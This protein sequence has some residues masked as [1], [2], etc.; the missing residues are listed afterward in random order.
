MDMI[1]IFQEKDRARLFERIE[2]RKL[3]VSSEIVGSVRQI[4]SQV[5]QKGDR[6]LLDFTAQF[7]KIKMT[8]RQLRVRPQ[9]LRAAA[10]NAD[11]ALLRE[12]EK[13]IF[14]IHAYHSREVQESWEYS[15][16]GVVL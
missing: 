4:I 1:R 5:Q 9:L 2:N 14:N 13:A 7:D 15:K 8:A 11:P 16:R 10:K 3:L 12:L 6:A